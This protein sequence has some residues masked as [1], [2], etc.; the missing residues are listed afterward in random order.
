MKALCTFLA[1]T[2][3]PGNGAV[4][5][6][7]SL[8]SCPG[9]NGDSGE[10]KSCFTWMI[11]SSR[12][13]HVVRSRAMF[14]SASGLLRGPHL[15]W[16]IAFC[17]SIR[18]RTSAIMLSPLLSALPDGPADIA[19]KAI[20]DAAPNSQTARSG[21]PPVF[22]STESSLPRPNVAPAGLLRTRPGSARYRFPAAKEDRH[23]HLDTRSEFLSLA[24]H[25]DEGRAGDAGLRR[26]LRSGPQDA[27]RDRRGRRRSRHRELLARSSARS[28]CRMPATS[29]IISAGTPARSCL[30][31]NAPHPHVERRY[32]VVPGLRSSRIHI[33]D[34]KPDPRNPKIVKVIEP[35]EVAEQGR[36]HA[37]A[38]R[39]LRPRGHLRR[40]ARQSPRARGR[41]ASS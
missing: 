24:A 12:A 33:L 18:I 1:T 9:R 28:R 39:A 38:H 11:G 4:S 23:G 6:R 41:A 19:A 34:T 13:R 30:C 37:A 35:E 7:K 27:R 16:L 15:G 14:F 25:G 5:G 22:A 36:L 40:R 3:S 26:R 17:W 2:V 21:R 31:P 10:V 20:A 8:P 29:C 32:L